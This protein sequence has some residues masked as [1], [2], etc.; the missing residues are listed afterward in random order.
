VVYHVPLHR[1]VAGMV[2]N[3]REWWLWYL[4][5]GLGTSLRAVFRDLVRFR[6][7][8]NRVTHPLGVPNGKSSYFQVG[9]S[10]GSRHRTPR[11][12]G[13]SNGKGLDVRTREKGKRA[14]ENGND[15]NIVDEVI[16]ARIT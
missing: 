10:T 4:N 9:P 7:F 15:S 3:N 2:A 13:H 12:T 6:D 11:V 1:V 8:R 14:K 5:H 16:T